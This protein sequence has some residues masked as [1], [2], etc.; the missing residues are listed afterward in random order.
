M[1]FTPK[2]AA[3][4]LLGHVSVS[5]VSRY[6]SPYDGLYF[7]YGVKTRIS[8]SRISFSLHFSI[9]SLFSFEKQYEE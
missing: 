6:F 4:L 7:V 9:V 5:S 8:T 1:L 2:Y 3:I